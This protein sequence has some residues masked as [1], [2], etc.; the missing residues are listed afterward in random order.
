MQSKQRIFFAGILA[1]GL[2]WIFLSADRDGTSTNGLIPAPQAGFLA[3]DFTLET[4]DGDT[5]KLSDLRGQ[6]VIVN[7][8]ATWCPP[9]KAEMPALQQVYEEYKSRGLIVLAVNSTTQDD[10][11]AIPAFIAEYSLTFPVL[12]DVNNEAGQLYQLRSLPSTF[13]IGRDGIIHEVVIGGPMAEALLRT[14]VEEILK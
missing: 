12:L 9:C 1:L 5:V 13:F 14:R 6:A 8:W 3:P 2:V 11:Q 7:L 10:A 4:M